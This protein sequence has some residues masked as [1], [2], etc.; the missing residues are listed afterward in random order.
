MEMALLRMRNPS[1]L[2][3]F[4]ETCCKAAIAFTLHRRHPI[5]GNVPTQGNPYLGRSLIH[6]P[7]IATRVYFILR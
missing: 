3:S 2:L 1:H 4:V 6:T 7:T 5:G